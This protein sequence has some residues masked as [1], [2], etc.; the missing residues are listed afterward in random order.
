MGRSRA[1]DAPLVLDND[2]SS[3]M[4]FGISPDDIDQEAQLL[5]V[6]RQVRAVDNGQVF[7]RPK[8]N[9]AREVPLAESVLRLIG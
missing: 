6:V 1:A 2:V 5:R 4:L 8:R 7:S 3:R 9:K